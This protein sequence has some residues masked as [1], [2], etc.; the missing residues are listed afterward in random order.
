M[1]CQ[2]GSNKVKCGD[3]ALHSLN[4]QHGKIGYINE[5]MGVYVKH[6]GGI[7]S[8]LQKNNEVEHDKAII[9]FYDAMSANLDYKYRRII[10]RILPPK[11]LDLT[12]KCEKA[13]D[14]AGAKIYG[15]R[16]LKNHF[17]I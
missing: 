10:N 6:P 9:E 2:I 1:S 15:L 17:I 13:G 3:W 11:L 7:W 12:I 14:L 4:A 8:S 5:I 16:C